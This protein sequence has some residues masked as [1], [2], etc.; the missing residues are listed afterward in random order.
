MEGVRVARTTMLAAL[1]LAAVG[2]GMAPRHAAAQGDAREQAVRAMVQSMSPEQI[3]ERLR[4]SG[5]SRAEVKERLR[6]AGY[7]AALADPY[8]DAIERGEPVGDG[9]AGDRFAE[10]LRSVGVTLRADDEPGM[11]A[12][13]PMAPAPEGAGDRD[14]AT[15]A[16]RDTAPRLFGRDVFRRRSSEFAPVLTGPVGPD[17]RLGPGDE[18]LL[19]ITGDVE[20]A[21]DL[22]VTREGLVLVPDV[23][24]V[25][26]NGL[27]LGQ[28]RLRLEERLSEAYS[29]I[30]SG[31]ARFTVSLGRLR[32]NQVRVVGEVE[33]PG[34]Y[35]MSSVS[36]VLE[37]LYLAGGPGEAGSFRDI[38][39]RR[40][41]AEVARLD[42]YPYLTAGS[43]AGDVRLEE[44]DVVF[45]PTTGPRVTL[46]GMVR[47]PAIFE[48]RPGEGLPA[49]VRY[50]GGLLPDARTDRVQ[51]DRILPPADRTEGRDRVLLDAPLGEVLAGSGAFDLRDG[52]AVEV[53]A[54]LSRV[55][56]RVSVDGAVWRPGAY[57]L[58]PGTTVAS[59]VQRAGG[60]VDDALA[61][62]VQLSRLDPADGSRTLERLDLS[63][64]GGTLLQE[65]DELTIFGRDSLT[66]T[67]SVAVYGF[68]RT[69][70]RYPLEAGMTPTDLIL[71]AGGFARGAR[72]WA[73]E[74]VR[75]D[76][77]GAPDAVL[78]TSVEVALP[79]D[80][81][82]PD[83]TLL[84]AA[85]G[86]RGGLTPAADVPLLAGDE[87]F[88]RRLAQYEQLQRV[89]VEGAVV[90]PGPYGL[91]RRDE[92]LS[93]V[94]ERAGGFTD[95]AYP[96]GLRLLRDGIPVGVDALASLEAPGT[97]A[98]PVLRGGDR[99]VVPV[100]DNT[101]AIR[102]AVL[103]EARTV[104]RRGMSLEDAIAAAGGYTRDAD[105]GR[106]SVE[107]ANGT[108]DA[109]RKTLWIFNDDPDIEPGATVF[110]PTRERGE[111]FDWDSALSRTLAVLSTF[112]TVYLA[113]G[114]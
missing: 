98:D 83:P 97:E 66:V 27:T 21:H 10:A 55:R 82:Y 74:V 56:Q 90:S 12:P 63:T 105:R 31:T 101:V 103:F 86:E 67:D 100:E 64:G 50:A 80:L 114:R 94:L 32:T 25:S 72:P 5:L 68:V 65:F 108:R 61:G 11:V 30:G 70:G 49:V 35:Q 22:T 84:A 41:G 48:L 111:G 91:T 23:G 62:Y 96:R 93:S 9:V 47:R 38:V 45:V 2:A 89:A 76:R 46:R 57:E 79:A 24:Q 92:R 29:A 33:R 16:A 88:V 102:G 58:R 37:A 7:D 113:V 40:G 85:D 107:Y 87:V 36:T 54:V 13:P 81:P 34:A 51:V 26:V 77:S 109:V 19:V 53:F 52:D 95:E 112:A 14:G 6:R 73:A 4:A 42:L 39:V 69:P 75:L 8:F 59:L 78:S 43:T 71:R 110:V 99:I 44:G 1:L 18:L 60:L 28:L 15:A 106:V 20:L 3:V 17:Y 104:Y